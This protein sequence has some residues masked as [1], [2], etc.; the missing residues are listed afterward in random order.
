MFKLQFR[1][2][3]IEIWSKAIERLCKDRK[4]VC[5]KNVTP[6]KF[7][8]FFPLDQGSVIDRYFATVLIKCG[9][10]K[11]Q[12][13]LLTIFKTIGLEIIL[14]SALLPLPLL[15]CEITVNF[16]K[17]DSYFLPIINQFFQIFKMQEIIIHQILVR[18]WRLEEFY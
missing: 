14:P 5:W 7:S 10:K 17:V 13:N 16:N 1:L 15:Q 6:A 18:S 3:K 8:S 2:K 11:L 4:G 9:S 12:R